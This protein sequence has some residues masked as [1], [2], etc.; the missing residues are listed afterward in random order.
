MKTGII[1]DIQ[2]YSLHDGPGIRTSV[3]FKGCNMRCAWCHNPE[4]IAFEPEILL[5]PENCI[6]C[7]RCDE[8][9]FA[10][11]KILCGQ[12]MTV[13]EVVTQVKLDAPYYKGIGGIT[14]TG[15]EPV[16]QS[17]FCAAIFKACRDEGIHTAIETNLYTN[18]DNLSQILLYVDLVMADLKVFDDE[19]HRRWIGV[20]NKLIKEN[21]QRISEAGI[22]LIVRT[23]VVPGVN[24]KI[25]EIISIA[26]FL[27]QLPSLEYYELL[28]YHSLG[29]SK[30]IVQG[31]EYTKFSTPDNQLLQELGKEAAKHCLTVY[32]AGTSVDGTLVG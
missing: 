7:M 13:A 31:W 23:P 8:E 2:R 11:A 26:S 16:C 12:K 21:I 30:G 20:G 25:E 4:T 27:G 15:G 24:A 9:C 10:D 28:P 3:F 14:I 29:L 17:E 19:N 1:T 32:I 5:K 22:P 6:G 18:W